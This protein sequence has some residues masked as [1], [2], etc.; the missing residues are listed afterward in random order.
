MAMRTSRADSPP[1]DV[2][3]VEES[4]DPRSKRENN[5]SIYSSFPLR[6]S[7]AYTVKLEPNTGIIGPGYRHYEEGYDSLS[8]SNL[9][10]Q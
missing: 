7:S 8:G 2:K 9:A 4:R 3:D 1:T 6:D 5:E 10:N